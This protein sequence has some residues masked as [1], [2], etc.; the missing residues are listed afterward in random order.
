MQEEFTVLE[1]RAELVK[2]KVAMLCKEANFVLPSDMEEALKKAQLLEDSPIGRQVLDD[3][4]QNACLARQERIPLCQDTGMVI[5]FVEI[6]QDVRVVGESLTDAINKG[7]AAG[8]LDGYLRK[9]VVADPLRRVNTGNNTPAVIYY[10]IVTEDVFRLTVMPK[11][12]GSENCT[13]LKMLKPTDGLP[14]IKKCIID[15][16]DQAGANPCP[17]V[18][19][20]V[21]LGGTADKAV[22]LS[23]RALLRPLGSK[24]A[25]PYLA[26]LETEL[27]EQINKLGHGPGGLGGRVTTVGVHIE[28]YPTH[29]AGLP[30]A[31]SI[32]C[33]ALR[34]KTW[35]W[36]G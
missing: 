24:H 6:G 18:V 29:I 8:Y 21:G 22:V 27:K 32:S 10:E 28:T 3:L 26:D 19:V 2:E 12:F 7:V 33:H 20:G 11:G 36:R 31:V 16:V 9:S 34:H 13:V 25:D 5:V 15:A 23:R 1:L 4:C 14:G 17:P 35:V 30:V